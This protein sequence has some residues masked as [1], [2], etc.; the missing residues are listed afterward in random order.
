MARSVELL[1]AEALQLAPVERARLLERLIVSLDSDPEWE[2]AWM[3][4]ADRREAEI[5]SGKAEW[6]P[7]DEVIANLRNKL[8]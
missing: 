3:A 1:E 8:A 4:E 5:A 6:L 7:G 2:Q